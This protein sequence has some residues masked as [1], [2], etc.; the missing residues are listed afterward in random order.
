MSRRPAE[1]TAA[2]GGAIAV[3][4]A[5][6]GADAQQV[7]AIAAVGGLLPAAVTWLVEHGG[8]RGLA[9]RVWGGER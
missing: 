8:I 1:T 2:G 7:A 4:A 6:L 3:I 5:A 9:R